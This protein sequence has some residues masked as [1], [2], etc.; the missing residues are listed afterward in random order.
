MAFVVRCSIHDDIIGDSTNQGATANK[1]A[2][3]NG[4]PASANETQDE[5][6]ARRE[7][8]QEHLHFCNTR[9]RKDLEASHARSIDGYSARA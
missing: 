8:P 9:L 4:I 7:Q 1:G 5:S 3:E 6:E 2:Q